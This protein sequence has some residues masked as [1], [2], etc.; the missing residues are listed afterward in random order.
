MTP[1]AQE[2][3]TKINKWDISN[4][5][6]SAQQKKKIRNKKATYRIG[7]NICKPHV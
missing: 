1:K 6:A 3:K 4:Y 5:K 7:E 2:T